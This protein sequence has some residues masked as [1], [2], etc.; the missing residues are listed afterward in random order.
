MKLHLLAIG[1]VIATLSLSG[2]HLLDIRSTPPAKIESGNDEPAP[3]VNDHVVVLPPKLSVS[4][5]WSSELLPFVADLVQSTEIEG[6]NTLLI[7]DIN[8]KTGQ[9]LAT[10]KVSDSLYSLLSEQT[11]FQVVDAVQVNQA[12]QTLNMVA[13]DLLVKRSKMIGLA[14][15]LKTTYLLFT[16]INKEPISQDS[17]AE[18]NM[19]LLSTTTGEIIWQMSSTPPSQ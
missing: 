13:D 16:T 19:E 17:A 3:V 5:D 15:Q 10:N 7:G 11:R 6:D 9:Y 1:I 8:N 2:C 18:I 4:L 14:R 12:K